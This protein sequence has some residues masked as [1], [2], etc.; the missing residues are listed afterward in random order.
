[1]AYL[2][3][4]ATTNLRPE[5]AAAMMQ[6][7]E[8]TGNPSSTHAAGR[9]ARR[10]VEE[11]REQIA[12]VFKASPSEVVFTSG[13][14]ESD[15][16]AVKGLHWARI[17][18]N[19]NRRIIISAA[20]EHHAITETIEWLENTNQAQAHWVKLDELGRVDLPA[21]ADFLAAEADRVSL[22][23]IMW[24]NN[25]SGVIQP[26]TEIVQLANQYEIPVHS[27][28]VQAASC[29]EIDFPATGLAALTFTGHKLG[30]PT[31]IG[32]LLLQRK[33]SPVP[34]L[35]GGGQERDVRSGTIPVGLIAAFAAALQANVADRAE[36]CARM[37]ELRE[38]TIE[39]VRKAVPSVRVTAE[40]ADR[41]CT[42]AHFTFPDCDGA[43][44]LMLLD[45][46]GIYCSSG[47]ACNAGVARPSHVLSAMGYSDEE[48][49]GA[50]RISFG[51]DTN[52]AE[53]DELVRVLPEVVATAQSANALT[54]AHR[55]A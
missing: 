27:D 1:M 31:G 20:S 30:A 10:I 44:L 19:A 41:L 23:S 37:R 50:L 47:S 52:K 2:D 26:I 49:L 36:R 13:G 4:A 38:Y 33:Y 32:G 39:Q 45:D 46:A 14:T 25:E 29:I 3:H 7:L 34:V 28:A 6:A 11:A 18:E 54:R 9:G 5:A 24:G 22:I 43:I 53:I 12:Q 21:L 42:I 15:N 8:H 16:Q 51:H 17:A 35:H 40:A 48:G 55:E